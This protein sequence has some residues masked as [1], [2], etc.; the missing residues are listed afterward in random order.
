M[1]KQPKTLLKEKYRQICDQLDALPSARKTPF[2][3]DC[4]SS[5]NT[6]T[7]DRIF[8]VESLIELHSHILGRQNAYNNSAK[9]LDVTVEPFEYKGFSVEDW[10]HDFK[11]QIEIAQN[12][13]LRHKLTKQKHLMEPYMEKDDQIME[14]LKQL[15]DGEI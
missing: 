13:N 4:R 3:T 14:L 12:Q 9:T 8:S 2:K 5:N 10:N 7:I 15:E 1:A 6:E 11:L